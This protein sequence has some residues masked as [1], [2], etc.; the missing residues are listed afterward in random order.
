[1][2]TKR[3]RQGDILFYPYRWKHQPPAK[4]EYPKDRPAC[5]A[6]ILRNSFG[7]DVLTFRPVSDLPPVDI[8]T[9]IEL[10]PSE[11][12]AMGLSEMRLAFIHLSEANVD[13]INNSL[14]IGP[15]TRTIG[16][17]PQS[18][19]KRMLTMLK[20]QLLT[21]NIELIHRGRRG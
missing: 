20:T 3:F 1:M 2:T 17:L 18:T 13:D 8:A 16:R 10:S 6:L 5:I 11:L 21:K 12:T 4:V 15:K 7:E 19:L 14:T 9:A